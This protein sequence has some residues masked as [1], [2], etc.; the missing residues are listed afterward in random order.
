[1]LSHM[2]KYLRTTSPQLFTTV[3][4]VDPRADYRPG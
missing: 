1:M 3:S 2:A 4:A